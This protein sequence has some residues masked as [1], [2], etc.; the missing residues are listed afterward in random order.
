VRDLRCGSAGKP[1]WSYRRIAGCT[2]LE[3]GRDGNWQPITNQLAGVALC[4]A[5]AELLGENYQEYPW[6]ANQA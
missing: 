1:G 4:E 3:W 5:A 6:Q 2:Y